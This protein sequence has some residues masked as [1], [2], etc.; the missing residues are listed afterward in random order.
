MIGSS[1]LNPDLLNPHMVSS[2]HLVI[3]A[4]LLQ[5]LADGSGLEATT[6]VEA[7]PWAGE[8]SACRLKG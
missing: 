3:E 7:S 1:G 8:L 5:P 4:L 2:Q 6:A